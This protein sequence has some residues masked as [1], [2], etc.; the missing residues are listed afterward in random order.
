MRLARPHERG[1]FTVDTSA[2]YYCPRY[3]FGFEIPD[4]TRDNTDPPWDLDRDGTAFV[5]DRLM[6][7]REIIC[8]LAS[9]L[10]LACGP[11]RT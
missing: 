7:K 2:T 5:T 1:G 11:R 3:S 10:P 6:M 8:A 4:E 9:F